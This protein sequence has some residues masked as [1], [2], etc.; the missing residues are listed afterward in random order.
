[1]VVLNDDLHLALFL[2]EFLDVLLQ[3]FRIH[4][5]LLVIH[6]QFLAVYYFRLLLGVLDLGF[7]GL[8]FVLILADLRTKLLYLFIQIV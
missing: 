7:Q 3:F 8:T 5:Y 4:R 1:M 2:L 6:H